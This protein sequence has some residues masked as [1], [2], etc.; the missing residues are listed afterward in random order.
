MANRRHRRRDPPTSCR[1]RTCPKTFHEP[2]IKNSEVAAF[3]PRQS[4][5]C[6]RR[7]QRT[8]PSFP[9]HRRCVGKG[10]SSLLLQHVP[11][12]VAQPA[13]PTEH[14]TFGQSAGTKQTIT[15]IF[16]SRVHGDIRARTTCSCFTRRQEWLLYG[17]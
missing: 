1:D 11:Q 10:D 7:L 16:S 15:T 12:E 2:I 13:A 17:H 5:L 9:A 14:A 8:V 4:Q 3:R 6:L